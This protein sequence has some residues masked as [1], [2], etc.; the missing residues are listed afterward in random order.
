MPCTHRAKA[1]L[2]HGPHGCATRCHHRASRVPARAKCKLHS[3]IG[4]DHMR[5]ADNGTKSTAVDQQDGPIQY[6][7]PCCCSMTRLG[8]AAAA[9]FLLCFAHMPSLSRRSFACTQLTIQKSYRPTGWGSR[10]GYI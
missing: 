9:C 8:M 7:R 3:R 4:K 1:L 2:K 5:L 6:P 10:S